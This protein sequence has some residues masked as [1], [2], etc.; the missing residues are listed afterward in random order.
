MFM[1]NWSVFGEQNDM[2]F[3]RKNIGYGPGRFTAP[4]SVGDLISTRLAAQQ[5]IFG[6]NYK[7]NF[8]GPVVAKC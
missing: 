5:V 8:G 1:P 7:F 3:G 2:D 6:V 4:G